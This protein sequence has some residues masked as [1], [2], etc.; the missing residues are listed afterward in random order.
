MILYVLDRFYT[1]KLQSA[2]CHAWSQ[3]HLSMSN[4]YIIIIR[5]V[6]WRKILIT[7][8][9]LIRTIIDYTKTF[10]NYDLMIQYLLLLK[11][12]VVTL[13]T[14][15]TLMILMTLMTLM[16]LIFIATDETVVTLMTSM[17]LIYCYWSW[18][19]WPWWLCWPW[20]PRRF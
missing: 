7:I 14:L 5:K 8:T 11:M 6:T 20:W 15:K 9:I 2:K 18:Y 12:T 1:L 4:Q 16:I 3:L 10:D 13:M 19:W 17:I